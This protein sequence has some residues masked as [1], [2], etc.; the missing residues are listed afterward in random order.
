MTKQQKL[1]LVED[2]EPTAYHRSRSLNDAGFVVITARTAAQARSAFRESGFSLVL[3]DIKL[4]DGNGYELCR[5]FRSHSADIPVV[6]IS[7]VYIDDGA[8]AAATFAGA[9]DFLGEPVPAAAL[10]ASVRTHIADSSALR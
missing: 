7:A 8:R 10:I 2:D 3:C 1:L 4:P 6:L 5:E 9:A